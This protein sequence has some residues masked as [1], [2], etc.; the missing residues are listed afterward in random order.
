[1]TNES[2]TPKSPKHIN[3]AL[4]A[5]IALASIAAGGIVSAG[6]V[7]KAQ[8]RNGKQNI[9]SNASLISEIDDT[10]E[11]LEGRGRKGM[12]QHGNKLVEQAKAYGIDQNLIDA[13]TKAQEKLNSDHEALSQA[14]KSKQ[15]TSQLETILREDEKTLGNVV[16]SLKDAITQAQIN[17]AAEKGVSQSVIDDWSNALNRVQDDQQ[18][19]REARDNDYTTIGQLKQLRNTLREDTK[20]LQIAKK[21]FN[22]ALNSSK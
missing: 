17:E 18:T 21:A 8:S 13:F 5:S 11:E 1:M 9:S 6:V 16:Q 7:A 2:D 20:E 3:T 4:V 19:L 10:H 15:D 22:D 14:R 12:K